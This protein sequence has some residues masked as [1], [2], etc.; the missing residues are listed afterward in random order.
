[1][2]CSTP[3]QTGEQIHKR[4]LAMAESTPPEERGKLPDGNRGSWYNPCA[5]ERHESLIRYLMDT[6]ELKRF[7]DLGAGDLRLSVALADDYEVV[8]YESLKE[9][10]TLAYEMHGEPDIELRT[11]DYYHHWAAMNDRKALFAAIGRTNELPSVPKNGI[12]VEGHDSLTVHM[13]AIQ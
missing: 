9:I 13:E 6:Y 10:A 2:S 4:A 3:Y 1:M 7:Y 11:T 5:D 8:A 12:G